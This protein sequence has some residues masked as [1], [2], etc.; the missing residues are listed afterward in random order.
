MSYASYD[1]KLKLIKRA[2]HQRHLAI[3]SQAGRVRRH[4]NDERALNRANTYAFRGDVGTMLLYWSCNLQG[5]S[6]L[7]H[8]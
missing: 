8:T 2:G 7:R 5:L 6:P 4:G 1:I 3:G